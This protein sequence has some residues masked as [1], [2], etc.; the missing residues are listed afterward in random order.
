MRAVVDAMSALSPCASLGFLT[1]G[2]VRV[3]V[4]SGRSMVKEPAEVPARGL[5]GTVEGED[6]VVETE[7]G[8]A[9]SEAEVFTAPEALSSRTIASTMALSLASSIIYLLRKKDGSPALSVR[10]PF[11]MRPKST[12]HFSN[13]GAG[14]KLKS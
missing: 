10:T 6:K 7:A 1:R 5:T 9:E 12:I 4:G 8:A 13:S 14:R 2:V 3:S 11:F